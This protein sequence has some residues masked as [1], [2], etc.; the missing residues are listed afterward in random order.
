[1]RDK[2]I[3]Y[4]FKPSDNQPFIGTQYEIYYE[5]TLLVTLG[6]IKGEVVG[7]I[8]SLLNGAYSNGSMYAVSLLR[9]NLKQK[10]V[11]GGV[12]SILDKAF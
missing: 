6:N 10:G 1:M 3:P 8:T 12:S 7:T 11:V 2:N 4:T 9:Q 5:G